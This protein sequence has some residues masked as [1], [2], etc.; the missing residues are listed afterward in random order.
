EHYP[1]S[2]KF[3]QYLRKYNTRSSAATVGPLHQQ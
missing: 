1:R 2:Q 3:E